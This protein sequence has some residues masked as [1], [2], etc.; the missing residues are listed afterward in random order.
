MMLLHSLR[1]RPYND[2]I[3]CIQEHLNRLFPAGFQYVFISPGGCNEDCAF[4][5]WFRLLLIVGIFIIKLLK[6]VITC[7]DK[8]LSWKLMDFLV[9]ADFFQLLWAWTKQGI[10]M[11]IR[12]WAKSHMG[13]GQ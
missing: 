1:M 9:C 13:A 11:V 12:S 4:Y 8:L 7:F 10:V 3:I 2:I 6:P 5:T